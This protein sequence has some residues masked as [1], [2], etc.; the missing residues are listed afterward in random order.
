MIGAHYQERGVSLDE[1][2]HPAERLLLIT[3]DVQLYEVERHVGEHLINA[4]FLQ[5][6]A[7]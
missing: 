1:L 5:H 6:D 7:P 4:S 3:L 2:R